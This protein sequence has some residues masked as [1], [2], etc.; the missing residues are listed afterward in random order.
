MKKKG[1]TAEQII[2]K[3]READV[4]LAHGSTVGEVSCKLGVARQIY[5][6]TKDTATRVVLSHSQIYKSASRHPPIKR[7]AKPLSSRNR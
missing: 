4:L 2:G 5:F 3:L 6:L 1:Y 7:I